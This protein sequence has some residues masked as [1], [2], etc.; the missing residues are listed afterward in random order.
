ML[1]WHHFFFNIY[2][3]IF[4]VQFFILSQTA[5][6]T[7]KKSEEESISLYHYYVILIC[8][9]NDLIKIIAYFINALQC[10]AF[11]SFSVDIVIICNITTV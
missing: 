2:T 11:I 6:D 8:N 5:K 3:Y 9:V 4:Y 1:N 7:L 10:F